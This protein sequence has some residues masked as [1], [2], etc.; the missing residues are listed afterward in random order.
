MW[1]SKYEKKLSFLVFFHNVDTSG[2]HFCISITFF[3]FILKNSESQLT[4]KTFIECSCY[5]RIEMNEETGLMSHLL[6]FRF[7]PVK[8]EIYAY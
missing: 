2:C 1:A 7:N 4:Q 3:F 5:H 6:S 8:T